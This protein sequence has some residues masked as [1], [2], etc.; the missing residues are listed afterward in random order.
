MIRPG[1]GPGRYP[2]VM[3]PPR[4]HDGTWVMR[5]AIAG[6]QVRLEALGADLVVDSIYRNSS[7]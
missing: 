5:V 4:L 2:T 1:P 7:I 6:G 3:V